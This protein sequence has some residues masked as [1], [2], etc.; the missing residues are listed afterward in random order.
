[1]ILHV[2]RPTIVLAMLKYTVSLRINII[3]YILIAFIVLCEY[4][5]IVTYSFFPSISEW[6]LSYT[7]VTEQRKKSVDISGSSFKL[8]AS[9]NNQYGVKEFDY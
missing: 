2:N 1:M 8:Y 7:K 5:V 3:H 9:V 4:I 6:L